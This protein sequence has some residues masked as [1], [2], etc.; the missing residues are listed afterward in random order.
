MATQQETNA[1]YIYSYMLKKGWTAQAVCGMLGNIQSESGIAVDIWEGGVGPGYGLVQ[2]TPASKLINW[3]NAQGLDYHDIS[4]QCAR[5]DYEMKNGIQFAPSVS[6]NLTG[7]QFIKST[8]PANTLGLVFLA[9]YER[10]LEPNQPQR[11]TQAAHWYSVLSGQ[12]PDPVDPPKPDKPTNQNK[13]TVKSGD[14]LSAIALKFG[15]TVAQLKKWNNISDTNSI[16]TGQVLVLKPQNN[17]S[18]NDNNSD[19][20]Q[21]KSYTVKSG[22]TL[23]EIAEKFNVSQSQ[24]LSWNHLTN[25]D[26]IQVGQKLIV[27]SNG[28]GKGTTVYTIK[29]GDTLS[30]I[31]QHFGVS[32]ANLRTWNHITNDDKIYAGQTLLIYN[33]NGG[34]GAKVSYTVQIGDTLSGIAQ[35]FGVSTNQLSS[36]N[37]ISDSDKIYVGGVLS[38]YT[39]GHSGGG[40]QNYTV[41]SG[42]T[43]SGIANKFNVST[44]Q[45]ISW[46]SISD[47][48]TIYAGQVLTV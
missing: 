44:D 31:A 28:G 10:P 6:Y 42:D 41:Q 13:Y 22:D 15:V 32:I 43:L 48:D 17:G 34:G 47:S 20:T 35:R 29:S 45:L 11:G 33:S 5:I 27:Y 39:S 24:L 26:K 2:W 25:A 14:T 8:E 38:I 36:W 30:D 16:K 40:T 46:N 7:N 12:D 1:R 37:N 9:N 23:S 4:A 3:C 18:N 21:Q 19:Q